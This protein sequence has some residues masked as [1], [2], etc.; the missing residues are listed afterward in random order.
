M[1][2]FTSGLQRDTVRGNKSKVVDM[3]QTSPEIYQILVMMDGHFGG[4]FYP[5][6]FKTEGFYWADKKSS[7]FDRCYETAQSEGR[8]TPGGYLQGCSNQS[9]FDA[10]LAWISDRINELRPSKRAKRAK[11]ATKD[12]SKQPASN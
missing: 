10:Q 3:A 12:L 2:L 9:D 1:R 11:R 5:Q 6:H 4:G 8:L 7:H